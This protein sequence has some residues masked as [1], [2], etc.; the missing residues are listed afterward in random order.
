[1]DFVKVMAAACIAASVAFGQTQIGTSTTYWQLTGSGTN[2]MLTISGTGD[3]PNF[4][5]ASDQPWYSQRDNITSVVISS[6]VTSIGSTAFR[7]VS[8]LTSVTI[9]GTVTSIAYYAFGNCARLT[10]VTIPNSVTTISSIAFTNCTGLTAFNVDD[11]NNNYA[12][13]DGVLFN[14]AE[15]S[16]FIYPAGK[17]ETTYTIPNSVT[18][19]EGYV[20]QNCS[21]LTSVVIPNSVTS[22]GVYAFSRCTGLTSVTIPNS[23]TSI[24]YGA[25]EI[26]T[27]LTSVTIPISVTSLGGYVFSGC[28]GL[29]EII[30]YRGSP[31]DGSIFSGVP[32][33]IPLYVP[34]GALSAYQTADLWNIFTNILPITVVEIGTQ[35]TAANTSFGGISGNLSVAA[36]ITENVPTEATLGYQWYSNATANNEDGEAVEG[37]TG[38]TFTLPAN[39]SAGTHYFYCVVSATYAADVVSATA[40]VTVA[41]ANPQYTAPT[42]LTTKVGQT[43]ADV[44]PALSGGWAWMNPAEVIAAPA[45]EQTHKAK[46]TPADAA[47]YNVLTDIDVKV[48]VSAATPIKNIQKSDGRFGI[49][50]SKN[51]VSD[52][53]EFEVILPNDK[54]LEVKA[55]IYDNTGNVVFEETE[56]GANVSW[57]LTNGAGRNVANGSYLIVVEAKSAK[58]TYA[59]S[60][61][62]GVKR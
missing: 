44:L 7:Y 12:S 6:G 27:G 48:A 62:V 40:T 47:N 38:A 26:C 23:V 21:K 8:K 58:G 37:A 17:T 19:I 52:K 28:T 16:L 45:G 55:I 54:V 30:N 35:P 15:T 9:P 33:N 25:F 18:S 50:L 41:K 46:F 5:N 49:R 22:I 32:R 60:A 4:T 42:N 61:K 24:G 2:Q 59:Y 53:A 56:R 29:T 14:K 36:S 1:M 10:S 13:I 57:N 34:G 20:F 11:D 43:L 39:L 3:M 31:Q 51:V